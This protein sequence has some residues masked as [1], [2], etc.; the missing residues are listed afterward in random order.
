[1]RLLLAPMSTHAETGG[2]MARIRAI[3]ACALRR[4]HTVA[5][6]AG[7]DI[8]YRPIDG[9]TNY[10]APVPAPFGL[11][12]AAGRHIFRW[13]KRFGFQRRIRIDD[14]EH[15]LHLIGAIRGRS[16][17]GDIA[18]LEKAIRNF[19]PD[20]VLADHRLG[21]LVAARLAGV[22]SA[23]FYSAPIHLSRSRAGSGR[24]S[25]AVRRLIRASGLPEIRSILDVYDWADMK[26]VPSAPELEPM[27]DSRLVYVGPVIEK[28]RPAPNRKR[29][30]IL[31]YV[32]NGTISGRR[33]ARVL[34]K[35]F[36]G[37]DRRI[38]IA[39]RDLKP[40]TRGHI[41]IAGRI[42]FEALLP[43]T[44]A[45]IGHGGQ[46]SIMQ[47][48]AHGVPMIL[49]P[50]YVFER[51]FNAKSIARLGA[52][53]ILPPSDF[54]AEKVR[55]AVE[56]TASD[57]IYGARAAALGARMSEFRGAEAILDRLSELSGA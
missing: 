42:D 2:S 34:T 18:C 1:M 21:P 20:V 32:G 35:A 22:L 19:R 36:A 46:N 39:S 14:F 53:L 7:E 23:V 16:F 38:F 8:N 41:R 5:L 55:E 11:P 29:T 43:E 56:R 33:L 48:L 25:A 17:A 9:L 40:A 24:F 52:G 15:V 27:N 44:A 37:S 28:T 6:C 26:F 47:C 4:G 10:P 31:A 54:T 30:A 13:I 3:A 50:G 49:S 51:C 45:F 12:S 57:P